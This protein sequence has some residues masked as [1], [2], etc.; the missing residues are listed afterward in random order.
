MIRGAISLR[1]WIFGRIIYRRA[2]WAVLL[3]LASPLMQYYAHL[4]VNPHAVQWPKLQGEALKASVDV[5][6]CGEGGMGWRRI[7]QVMHDFYQ[8]GL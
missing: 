1:I 8:N 7:L 2:L 4:A 6:Q 3:L 5:E